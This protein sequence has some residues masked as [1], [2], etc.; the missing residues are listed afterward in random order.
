[1]VKD[2]LNNNSKKAFFKAEIGG[3]SLHLK[4]SYDEKTVQQLVTY[5]DKK[6]QEARK[7]VKN[8]SFQAI[9]LLTALN[10]AEELL[11]LKKCATLDLNQIENKAKK[12]LACLKAV[13][14]ATPPLQKNNYKVRNSKRTDLS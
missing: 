13:Q 2:E 7:G 12:I 8:G 9:T 4:S 11:L 5:V 3:I 6:F 10:I 14:T 1:M